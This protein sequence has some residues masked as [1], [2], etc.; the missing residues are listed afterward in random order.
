ML[1]AVPDV[2]RRSGSRVRVPDRFAS[3]FAQLG[4]VPDEEFDAFVTSLTDARPTLHAEALSA[5]VHTS[6]PTLGHEGVKGL[7]AALV[8]LV[9]LAR[10]NEWGAD[11]AARIVA[12]SENVSTGP[13][14]RDDALARRLAAI[15]STRSIALLGKAMD[16]GTEH[17]RVMISTRILTDLRPVFNSDVDEAPGGALLTHTLKIEFVHDAGTV[18]NI[19]VAMDEDDIANLRA[20]LDRADQKG[21][22]LKGMIAK[23]GVSYMN[24]LS[25]EGSA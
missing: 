3:S 16:M 12:D 20:L 1:A 23:M 7:V 21:A 5:S 8:S 4:E 18:G 6:A 25:A 10:M 11:E 17:D 14:E 19:Y 9:G 24:P 22:T 2:R 13:A 15:L